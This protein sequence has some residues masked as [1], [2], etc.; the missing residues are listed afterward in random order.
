[1]AAVVLCIVNKEFETKEQHDRRI[2]ADL[3]KSRQIIAAKLGIRSDIIC[4]P[5]GIYDQHDIAMARKVGFEY[6]IGKLGY[7]Y[8]KNNI[9]NV[10]RVVVPGGIKLQQFRELADHRQVNYLQAMGLELLRVNYHIK[11]IAPL[12]M[13]PPNVRE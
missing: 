12:S 6:M 1:M 7:C 13:L 4:W 2:E 10:G 9:D 3:L 5:F 8:P 11:N